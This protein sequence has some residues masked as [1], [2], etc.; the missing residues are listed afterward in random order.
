[1]NITDL[2]LEKLWER[3]LYR[4]HELEAI[5]LETK[6]KLI[7]HR[8]IR[9]EWNSWHQDWKSAWLLEGS[10]ENRLATSVEK[11]IKEL[12]NSFPKSDSLKP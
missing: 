3:I 8:T 2:T 1:M 6:E 9:E 5:T 11:R 4:V 10:E 7:F 12:K